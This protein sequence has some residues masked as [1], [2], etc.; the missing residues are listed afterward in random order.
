IHLGHLMTIERAASTITD[1]SRGEF[2]AE[3]LP[4]ADGRTAQQ[5]SPIARRIARKYESAG[6]QKNHAE[7]FKERA[8]WTTPA[9]HGMEIAS[10]FRG[11]G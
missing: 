9:E 4:K 1:E 11:K 7:A 6:L 2:E 10:R 5:L 3:A 8:V